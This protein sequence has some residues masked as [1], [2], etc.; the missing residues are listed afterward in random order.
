MLLLFSIYRLKSTYQQIVFGRNPSSLLVTK[1]VG[2]LIVLSIRGSI[3]V[4]Q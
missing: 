3:L 1:K 2:N 4:Q